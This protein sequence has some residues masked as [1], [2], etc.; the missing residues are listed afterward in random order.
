MEIIYTPRAAEDL[1]F[2]K[3]SGDKIIQNK[4][5]KLLE[6]IQENPYEGI[7]KP[8]PLKY[9]L[10]GAWSRRITE[11]PRLVYE[12]NDKNEIVILTIFSLKGHY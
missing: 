7:G 3:R 12:V 11:E 6:A 9:K 5:E 1:K 2:C 4:I 10:T 8:E